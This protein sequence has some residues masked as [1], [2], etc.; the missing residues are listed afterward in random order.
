MLVNDKWIKAHEHNLDGFVPKVIIIR[1]G[2][3]QTFTIKNSK[4]EQEV[5]KIMREN[6]KRGKRK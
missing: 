4:A 3:K 5:I 6:R 2:S 1:P